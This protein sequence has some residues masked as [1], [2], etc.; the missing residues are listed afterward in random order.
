MDGVTALSK[1][2][3]L[4]Q[5]SDL[6][7]HV[8]VLLAAASALAVAGDSSSLTSIVRALQGN[9]ACCAV[10]S[11]N[12]DYQARFDAVRAIALSG[13]C[14]AGTCQHAR[15]RERAANKSLAARFLSPPS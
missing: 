1:I 14:H 11:D 10:I 9:A 7:A 2:M 12:L 8:P 13:S 4:L 3:P 6:A 15:A 5:S